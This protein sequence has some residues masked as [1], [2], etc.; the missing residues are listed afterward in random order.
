MYGTWSWHTYSYAFSFLL[1]T[2]CDRRASIIQVGRQDLSH[3][4]IR[5][6]WDASIPTKGQLRAPSSSRNQEP[7]N[8]VNDITH[9]LI[10]TLLP[11][12]RRPVNKENDTL[13]RRGWPG[14]GVA[15]RPRLLG[16]CSLDKKKH[17]RPSEEQNTITPV[18]MIIPNGCPD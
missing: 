16:L 5:P 10:R 17:I 6:R 8:E 4:E 15:H 7:S 18:I 11:V 1:K 12:N 2:G 14:R 3:Q 9:F 13:D